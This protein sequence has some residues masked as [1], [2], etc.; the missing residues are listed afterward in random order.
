MHWAEAAALKLIERS[1]NKEEYVCATGISPSGSIHIGNFRDIATSYFVVR[2]L[3]KLGKKAKLMHSWDN[4]DRLRK[5]PVNV[6][7]IAD[8][9]EKYIGY[10]YV[11]VSNPFVEEEGISTYA[12]HFENEFAE[13]LTAFG[14]E[15]DYRYQADMYRSGK[16]TKQILLALLKRGQ[17][18]D[19]LDSFRTQ[20][21]KEGERDS[22]YPVSIYCPVC[23]RDTTKI[24]SYD[25]ETHIAQYSC[26]CGHNAAF[27]F[28]T[29]F[30]CK[31]A[32]KVDWAMRWQYEEVD[33]EPGGADHAAPT[34]SYQTSKV[35]SKEIFGYEAPIFQAYSFIGLKGA[36][37]KMS[38][39]T[40][41][42]LTPKTLLKIYEPEVIL[43]LYSRTDP[44]HAFDFC[45]DD[46]ILRQYYEF[47]RMYGNVQQGKA[48]EMEEEIMSNCIIHN[49]KLNMVSMT[50]LVQFGSVVNFN[51]KVLETVFTKIGTP[52]KES[53]FSERLTLAKNWLEM[54]SPE[55]VNH[56]FANRNWSYYNTLSESE[57]RE[58]TVLFDNLSTNKYELDDLNTMIYA[59]PAQALGSTIEDAKQKKALQKTF[60]KNVYMLLIGKERGPRLYLFL[61]AL[62]TKQ[63]LH[64]FDFS[65]PMTDEE[66]NA[67]LLSDKVTDENDKIEGQADQKET[68]TVQPIKP[69]IK[70]EAF[71]QLD[72]RVCEI[73]KCQE[74]RKSNNCLKL[75]LDDGL[76]E[77]VIVSSISHDY[78]SD[79]LIG[80]KIIVIANLEPA[81]ITGVTSEGMLLA[82]TNDSDKCTVVFVDSNLPNGSVLS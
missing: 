81:R 69:H 8:N 70:M 73:I 11:D 58:I 38:G 12:S 29:D 40:G 36:S 32:W 57:K 66:K 78:T 52:Y 75:T 27:D 43:W 68:L 24:S 14:I 54:C 64:L 65:L 76:G 7:K 16:Y 39:S 10:P 28:N 47:D 25:E 3:W 18:F 20:E 33:F 35:I 79:E 21:A 80:K 82:T 26:K 31:L 67:A 62:E 34:G 15:P 5:I 1:P 23:K 44:L 77:R 2:A 19:I 55:S 4:F 72:L 71:E 6:A 48:S 49:R 17:I 60:F 22:Y 51:P 42:N 45:F 61:F 13:A 59:V 41:L 30:N 56:L 63:Y 50:W 37:G 74:I 53:E 9:M 46:G